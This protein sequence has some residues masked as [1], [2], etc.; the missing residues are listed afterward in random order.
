MVRAPVHPTGALV[1]VVAAARR[2]TTT[3]GLPDMSVDLSQMVVAVSHRFESPVEAVW[4]LLSDLPAM[5]AFS[6]EVVALAWTGP[7]TFT[8]TNRLHGREWT[9]DGH[10]VEVD[11]PRLLRWTVLDPARPSS[12]WEVTLVPEGPSATTVT[13]RFAHGPGPSGVRYAVEAEP[14]R[15]EQIVAGRSAML[16][17]AMSDSLD[18]AARAL[19]GPA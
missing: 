19:A 5:A 4:E 9:V 3:G 6:D 8:A 1:V 15:L 7:R 13:Q 2:T 12:T 10:L 18:R 16:R 17:Q 11:P 14:G